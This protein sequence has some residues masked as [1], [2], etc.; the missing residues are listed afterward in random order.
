MPP[1][2]KPVPDGVQAVIPM[3]VCADPEAAIGFCKAAFEAE[4]HTRRTAEDGAVLHAALTV[5]GA[6][7]FI[8][9][10]HP[11]LASRSPQPDATSPVV[12]F[13]YLPDV[14]RAVERAVA[15]G[16]TILMPLQ[17][18]FWGDR[19]ARIMDPSGHVWIT[20]SRIEETTT[21]ERAGRWSKLRSKQ[22]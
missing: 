12:I 8:E 17:D 6:M 7:F 20:A 11:G 21:E 16:A 2:T 9:A 15:A 18:Q 14:D 10:Q 22:S 1:A 13:V 4:E 3:L 19:T 5:G